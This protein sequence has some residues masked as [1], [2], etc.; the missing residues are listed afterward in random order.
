METLATPLSSLAAAEIDLLL[1]RHGQAE[2]NLDPGKLDGNL[3]Y[4]LTALGE[5]QS[6]Q[7]GAFLGS[8]AVDMVLVSDK[9]RAIQT[10]GKA[11]AYLTGV[12]FTID[13][14]LKEQDYG[15]AAGRRKSRVFG[16][17]A[18]DEVRRLGYD[19]RPPSGETG[20]EVH[21]R[22]VEAVLD[23]TAKVARPIGRN[24]CVAVFTHSATI[25]NLTGIEC[26]IPQGEMFGR[27]SR[28]SLENGAVWR[29]PAGAQEPQVVFTPHVVT[30]ATMPRRPAA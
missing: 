8:C 9:L 7:T 13:G 27:G 28:L 5:R 14:R 29:L 30:P 21:D 11:E 1:V 22:A 23:Q 12:P 26:G 24:L 19:Y 18:G 2:H 17:T 3:D 15:E 10:Y 20:R 6:V 4:A 16:G 25:R